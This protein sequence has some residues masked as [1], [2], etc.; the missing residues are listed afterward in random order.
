MTVKFLKKEFLL[1]IFFFFLFFQSAKSI[2]ECK[3]GLLK[4]FGLEAKQYPSTQTMKIC[5]KMNESCCSAGDELKIWSLWEKYS[6]LKINRYIAQLTEGYKK[7]FTYHADLIRVNPKKITTKQVEIRDIPM[8]FKICGRSAMQLNNNQESINRIDL[9]NNSDLLDKPG[10]SANNLRKNFDFSKNFLKTPIQGLEKDK[11]KLVQKKKSE[12][13]KDRKLGKTLVRPLN[14]EQ[15]LPKRRIE[16]SKVIKITKKQ[17]K[18]V[19]NIKKKFCLN[20]RKKLIEFKI[21]DFIYYVDDIQKELQRMIELKKSF[22]CSLCDIKRQRNIDPINKIITFDQAFCRRIVIEFKDYIKFQNVLLIEYIDLV[23]QYIRCF[24]SSAEESKFPLTTFLHPYR[25]QF[26]QIQN[27]FNGIDTGDFMDDCAFLCNQFSYTTLSPFW[28]GNQDLINRAN[29]ELFGFF[30]KLKSGLPLVLEQKDFNEVVDEINSLDFTNELYSDD[31]KNAD[32]EAIDEAED[33]KLQQIKPKLKKDINLKNKKINNFL[34]EREL[35]GLLK[36]M[37]PEK[38]QE[39]IV[40]TNNQITGENANTKD[41]EEPRETVYDSREKLPT[42]KIFRN[43]F[44]N[45]TKGINPLEMEN[46]VNYKIDILDLMKKNCKEEAKKRV[47]KLDEKV[48]SDYFQVSKKDMKDFE[49]DLFLPITEYAFFA[50][51][52]KE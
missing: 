52:N 10:F 45:S 48:I 38:K 37:N 27:C 46:R 24:Q 13:N 28:D 25:K 21:S 3:I 20:I 5:G 8:E 16:C 19:N 7:L 42:T 47:E 18:F 23:L 14:F 44:I 1:K 2:E 26:E 6:R 17:V 9:L 39:L 51:K 34:K 33:R 15:E 12:N 22:Y 35:H 50:K 32:Q 30:R 49:K 40:A 29:F 41:I 11:R 36:D 4:Y 43:R 31:A